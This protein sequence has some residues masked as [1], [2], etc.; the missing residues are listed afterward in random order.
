MANCPYCSDK[1]SK[2]PMKYEGT[3][4]ITGSRRYHCYQC[5]QD[6]IKDKDKKKFRKGQ[7]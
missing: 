6:F 2:V 1:I 7:W 3:S 4:K 5:G